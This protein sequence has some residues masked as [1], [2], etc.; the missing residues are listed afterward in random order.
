MNLQEWRERRNKGEEANLPSGLT[1][2]V[3]RVS[4]ADL[5][6]R[7]EIPQTLQPQFE[8]FMGGDSTLTLDRFKEFS[9]LINLI[10]EVCIVEP[11]ELDVSELPYMDRMSIFAWANEVADTLTTFRQE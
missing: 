4:V 8:K 3:K 11:K 6:E 5:A 1:I 7:G 9:G 2:H 10:C